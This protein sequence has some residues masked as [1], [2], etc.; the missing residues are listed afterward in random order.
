MGFGIKR[1][2]GHFLNY[3]NGAD[4]IAA[5]ATSYLSVG[6]SITDSATE[7]ARQV[8]VPQACVMTTLTIV[9]G[10]GQPG[11]GTLVLTVRKN[12]VDT[13][14]VLTLAAGANAGTYGTTTT[15]VAFAENDLLS[16]KAVNNAS[17]NSAGIISWSIKTL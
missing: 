10:N 16:V 6:G 3:T 13:A 11:S 9:T 5:G 8:L 7:T 12:G 4:V 15:A 1:K 17:G 14:V 2:L